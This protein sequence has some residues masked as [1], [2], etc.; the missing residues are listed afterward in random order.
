MGVSIGCNPF[1]CDRRFQSG[2][3]EGCQQIATTIAHGSSS[4]S[5]S[6]DAMLASPSDA[7][8]CWPVPSSAASS[9]DPRLGVAI[10]VRPAAIRGRWERGS[11][12]ETVL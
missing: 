9:S 3:R 6:T 1:H 11:G 8:R 4:R 12:H 10:A 7:R 2:T 5:D